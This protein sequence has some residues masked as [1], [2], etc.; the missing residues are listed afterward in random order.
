MMIGFFDVATPIDREQLAKGIVPKLEPLA[1]IEDRAREL[2]AQFDRNGDGKLSKDELPDGHKWLFN[3]LD[4]NHD[5]FLDVEEV[6][7][8]VKANEGKPQR[9]AKKDL[10]QKPA[11]PKDKPADK[12]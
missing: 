8:F 9:D 6:T 1:T 5:G 12:K 4:R 3:L 2:I 7:V 11:E 10:H